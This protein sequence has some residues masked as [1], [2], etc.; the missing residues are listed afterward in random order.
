M[1]T[2][3]A[4][5]FCLLA[6]AQPGQPPA[7]TAPQ[8]VSAPAP[9]APSTPS[10]RAAAIA[11]RAIAYLLSKQDSATGGW[12]VPKAG[13]QRPHLPAITALALTGMTMDPKAAAHKA[14]IDSAAKYILSHRKADGGIYDAILPSYNTAISLSA[15]AKVDSP[16]AKAAIKPA[17]E[18]LKRSQWG[19]TEPVG[20][21]GAG[22]KEAPKPATEITP[23]HPFYGGLGYGNRGRP[24]LSNLAFALQAWRDSELSVDDEAYKR[25]IIFIQRCQM[26][27]VDAAG[28]PVNDQPYA[29]D[30]K[31]L[32]FIYA[33]AENDQ[34]IG[35]G[36]SF[37][38]TI[39]E[40]LDNGQKV[41]KLRAYGS[42]TYAGFKSYL[43]AGLTAEDP[44][45]VAAVD[46]ARTHWTLQE[47]PATG[48]DG[49]YYFLV[50]FARAMEARNEPTLAVTAGAPYR[51]SALLTGIS[52]SA[53]PESIKAA[54]GGQSGC[55]KLTTVVLL[56]AA[57]GT[58]LAARSAVVYCEKE[59]QIAALEAA[60]KATMASASAAPLFTGYAT[61]EPV[62]AG[63]APLNWRTALIERLEAMQNADGSFVTIDD[64]WMENNPSLTTA[65]A[66]VALQHA[67]KGLK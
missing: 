8:R 46:W 15:L 11:D 50:M 9:S 7:P 47:N 54:I 45:V 1:G 53:T 16:E 30:S 29:K 43:F 55:P 48:S 61:S 31:Q 51:S 25:A 52:S 63:A 20:V 64:R 12:S 35:Q 38:G 36:Q 42:M 22:G 4:A 56:P 23:D 6:L 32:G 27:P 66:L 21:G 26:L 10:A 2:S 59:D 14:A 33:T 24:D 57:S 39:E 44:R 65:Y 60:I 58:S 49:Y 18:F 37:A 28:K 67:R 17:Q 13:E 34:T 62:A 19:T 3:S 41:S 40:T 5:V